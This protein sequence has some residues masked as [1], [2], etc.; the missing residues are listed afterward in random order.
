[1]K[2]P[3]TLQTIASDLGV[4]PT[5]VSRVLNHK[6]DQYRISKTTRELVFSKARELHFIPNPMARGLK[7]QKTQTIGLVIPDISNPFFASIAKSVEQE[8]RKYK[9]SIILCD[10]QEDMETEYASLSLL[11]Q[12]KVDGMIIAPVGLQGGAIEQI[13]HGG[14]PV[15]IVDRYFPNT[16]VPF[17]GSD[18]YKGAYH[19]VQYLIK[20]GHRHIAFIQGIPDTTPNIDRLRGY[21]DAL[22]ASDLPFNDTLIVGDSFGE[23]NGYLEMKILARHHPRPT[24]VFAA[25]NLISLGAL[26]ALAEKGLYV[27]DDISMISFDEQPYSNLLK[28]PMT[29]VAQQNMEIGQI[30]VKILFRQISNTKLEFN[31]NITLSTKMIVRDSV[32]RI[33]Q[34]L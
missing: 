13:H 17:V 24:A 29:T 15:V 4:S 32:K 3:T 7:M 18:N 21:R 5:T 11:E 28:T 20:A 16:D 1:M 12:R 26:K 30:A 34:S 14:T 6:A 22:Q 2:K 19:A 33:N 25:S 23:E 27:P 10:S 8:A 9:Y 31:K